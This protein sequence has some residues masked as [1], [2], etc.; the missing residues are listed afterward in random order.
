MNDTDFL[1]NIILMKVGYQTGETLSQIVA[2][3]SQE[4][5]TAPL[6]LDTKSVLLN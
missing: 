6:K 1:K 4:E 5:C 2:R 3:K